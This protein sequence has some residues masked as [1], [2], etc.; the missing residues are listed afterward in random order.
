M[1]T[2]SNHLQHMDTSSNAI[3]NHMSIPLLRVSSMTCISVLFIVHVNL[4]LVY[5]DLIFNRFGFI[6]SIN[7]NNYLRFRYFSLSTHPPSFT[8]IIGIIQK[9]P[10]IA[11]LVDQFLAARPH[12]YGFL[13]SDPFRSAIVAAALES[14]FKNFKFLTHTLK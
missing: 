10:F 9:T 2:I 11:R 4:L 1:K 14:G 13:P 5:S 3:Q 8:A 7:S 12:H 6:G